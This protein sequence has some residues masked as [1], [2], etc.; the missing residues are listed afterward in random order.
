MVTMLVTNLNVTEEA[1]DEYLDYELVSQGVIDESLAEV[2]GAE[3]MVGHPYIV[4]QPS[5]GEPVYLRFIEEEEKMNYRPMGTH[6]W[7]S[8]EILVQNPDQLATELES[9]PFEIIGMPYDLY[10]TPDAPRA[11]QV[12][13]PS[14]EVLYLTR[15]IPEGSG[16]NLGSAQSYVDRVFIMVL[17]GP[18]MEAL[19]DYYKTSFG[20]PVTEASDWTIGV[21]S[22]MNDLP[23]DSVFPLALVEF[24]ENFLIELDEWNNGDIFESREVKE[25]HLPPSTSMVSFSTTSIDQINVEWKHEPQQIDVFP[26]NGSKV[27]VTVGIA[28]EWIEIIEWE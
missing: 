27:G 25:G 18:S 6:G 7:N 12:L 14:D 2:W 21:L 20:M 17:G 4:M 26:Y 24:E 8:T 3:G 13:G 10:P 28:G 15:I 22:R 11:M 19:Q 5:S 1:Y 23:D 9:S 16:F